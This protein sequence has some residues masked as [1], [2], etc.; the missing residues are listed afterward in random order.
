MIDQFETEDIARLPVCSLAWFC[1]PYESD[2]K[3]AMRPF[4][5][6]S[7]LIGMQLA[8]IMCVPVD[9]VL[10]WLQLESIQFRRDTS[11][12]SS[13]QREKIQ[14]W[15]KLSNRI[16]IF[17]FWSRANCYSS[18]I[19]KS[20]DFKVVNCLIFLKNES[21]N[22]IKKKYHLRILINQRLIFTLKFHFLNGTFYFIPLFLRNI[23]TYSINLIYKLIY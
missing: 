5:E 1:L 6:K 4:Q 23:L 11:V 19:F 8:G 16:M 14:I 22:I 9:C 18:K 3:F 13:Y 17:P 10:G 21:T 20:C 2:N 12:L 7:M 15:L